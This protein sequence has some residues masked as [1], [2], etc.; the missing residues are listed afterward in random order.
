L[1]D[2]EGGKPR[3]ISAFISLV[4]PLS[5][6]R[7][8]GAPKNTDAPPRWDSHLIRISLDT[9]RYTSPVSSSQ[10]GKKGARPEPATLFKRAR[11]NPFFNGLHIG[12]LSPDYKNSGGRVGGAATKNYLSAPWRS[13]FRGRNRRMG[14]DMARV[15]QK[16]MRQRG[17]GTPGKWRGLGWVFIKRCR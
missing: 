10:P 17:G 11:R 7:A 2:L 16:T 1:N 15:L 3:Q 5:S 9:A 4:G 13:V 12:N 14:M 8:A 6:A